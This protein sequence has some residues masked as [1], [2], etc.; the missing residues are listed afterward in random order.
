MAINFNNTNKENINPYQDNSFSILQNS[1]SSELFRNIPSNSIIEGNEIF[2]LNILAPD[3]SNNTTVRKVKSAANPI[4]PSKQRN[5]TS[6]FQRLSQK[7]VIGHCLSIFSSVYK[8]T[9]FFDAGSYMNIFLATSDGKP[10][11]VV[12]VFNSERSRDSERT[13]NRY[14]GSSFEQYNRIKGRLSVAPIL[15]NSVSDGYIVQQKIPFQVNLRDPNQLKPIK[16]YFQY[17]LEN[18]EYLDISYE[19]FRV[20]TSG[21][22]YL[23]D[24]REDFE[25]ME[26]YNPAS[27]HIHPVVLDLNRALKSFERLIP[28]ISKAL[29]P[30]RFHAEKGLLPV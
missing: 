26:D 23:I 13:L 24:F 9:S 4:K 7:L 8:I 10:D 3:F 6:R 25:E 18:K 16:V 19:N 29:V 17:A 28:G 2:D 12:K 11:C 14:I 30:E 27:N 1:F 15:N 5:R 20:D 21:R 22:V